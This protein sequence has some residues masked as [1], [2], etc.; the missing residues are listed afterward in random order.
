MKPQDTTPNST[1]SIY[2]DGLCHLCS[3]EIDHYR[4]QQGSERLR[5]VDITHVDFNAAKEGVDP[6]K[7]H[8]VMHVKNNKG[9]YTGVDSFIEIWRY[10]P[11]Y[12][13]AAKVAQNPLVKSLLKVGYSIFAS[14]RPLLPKKEADCDQSPY[15]E[16]KEKKK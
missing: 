10:L 11:K 1:L 14:V 8:K 2:Y 3:R 16:I 4:K 7:V 13:T 12:K 9:I 6:V 15:C 5:F